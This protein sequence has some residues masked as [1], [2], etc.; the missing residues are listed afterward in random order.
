MNLGTLATHAA[1]KRVVTR[2]IRPIGAVFR[3]ARSDAALSL[4]PQYPGHF[5][6][7]VNMWIR[8]HWLFLLITQDILVIQLTQVCTILSCDSAAITVS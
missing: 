5:G 2:L 8:L 6:H 4:S 3:R 7:I 1:P